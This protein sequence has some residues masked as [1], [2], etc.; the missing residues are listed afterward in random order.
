MSPS[1]DHLHNYVND[2]FLSLGVD[3][4]RSNSITGLSISIFTSGPAFFLYINNIPLNDDR[5]F[6]LFLTEVVLLSLI[7]LYFSKKS[8][9]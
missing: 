3:M 4:H 8:L 9:R 6:S 1:N 7:Y 5:W 2:L